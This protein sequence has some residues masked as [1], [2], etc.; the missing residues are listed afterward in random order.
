MTLALVNLDIDKQFSPPNTTVHPSP[1]ED[2][3]QDEIYEARVGVPL[4][5][6]Q[7]TAPANPSA[8]PKLDV[9]KSLCV[10]SFSP[11]EPYQRT[12]QAPRKSKR[13]YVWSRFKQIIVRPTSPHDLG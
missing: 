6:G 3:S 12:P 5:K 2:L 11:T 8:N 10:G 13:K 4:N 1:F 7:P 9:G